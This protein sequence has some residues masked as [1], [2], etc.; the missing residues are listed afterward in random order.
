MKYPHSS[1]TAKLF[2]DGKASLFHFTF[3]ALTEP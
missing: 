3:S 2:E 1:V